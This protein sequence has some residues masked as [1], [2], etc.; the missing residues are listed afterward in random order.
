MPFEKFDRA[1]YLAL[2]AEQKEKLDKILTNQSTI[3]NN[4]VH[5]LANQDRIFEFFTEVLATQREILGNQKKIPAKERL[6]VN[7]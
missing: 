5:L 1:T 2:R 7:P 4:Q 3:E 6:P